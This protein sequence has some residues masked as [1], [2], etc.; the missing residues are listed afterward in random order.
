MLHVKSGVA[1]AFIQFHLILFNP[2]FNTEALNPVREVRHTSTAPEAV[3]NFSNGILV[4]EPGRLGTKFC[5]MTKAVMEMGLTVVTA[6]C[7]WDDRK[8]IE[9]LRMGCLCS[10]CQ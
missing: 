10:S 3:T 9:R 4:T 1:E 8:R 7:V 2:F 6:H 5:R